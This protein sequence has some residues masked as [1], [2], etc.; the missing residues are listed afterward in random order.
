[1]NINNNNIYQHIKYILSYKFF[2]NILLFF[3]FF[4]NFINFIKIKNK[5]I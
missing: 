1:M 5:N 2:I 4:I 3:I